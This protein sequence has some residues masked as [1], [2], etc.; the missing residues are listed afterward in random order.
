MRRRAE[1][2]E[3]LRRVDV[4]EILGEVVDDLVCAGLD[5]R[6][7]RNVLDVRVDVIG[8]G[9]AEEEDAKEEKEGQ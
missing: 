4:W 9:A 5:L 7:E 8:V 1:R 6:A 2:I 3:P